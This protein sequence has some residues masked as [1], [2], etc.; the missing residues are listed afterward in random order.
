M[1]DDRTGQ[2]RG[3]VS[4]AH[5]YYRGKGGRGQMGEQGVGGGVRVLLSGNGAELTCRS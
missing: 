5:K 2:S 1:V 4:W 3:A